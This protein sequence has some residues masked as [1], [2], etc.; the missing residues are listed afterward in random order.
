MPAPR[1]RG[2]YDALSKI[3]QG[4]ARQASA[5]EQINRQLMEREATLHSGDWVGKGATA[6]YREMDGEVMPA[7][8][9]LAA[10]LSSAS[11][12][13]RQI[14]QILQAA[15]QEAARVFR[16]DGVAG[17]VGASAGS[18]AGSS[19][20]GGAAGPS[21]G[22]SLFRDLLGAL[23]AG[24]TAADLLAHLPGGQRIAAIVGATSFKYSLAGID[25]MA[26]FMDAQ[27]RGVST[28]ASGI[29]GAIA[30]GFGYFSGPVGNV[31][32]LVHGVTEAIS[33][34][35]GKYTAIVNDVMPMNVGSALSRGTVDTVDAA[36]RGDWSQL[37]RHHDQ[38]MAGDYGEVVRGYA[39]GFDALGAWVTGD[40]G[41]LGQ[42]SNMAA[43]GSLGPLA[44]FGDWLGGATY[45]LFH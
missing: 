12:V 26:E 10:A 37:A 22:V 5:L 1:V 35:A 15:E 3:A 16:V 32:G 39:I 9:R 8:K 40:S 18:G 29:D 6:F 31:V 43:D 28:A 45:D 38:N 33:P 36:I 19:G 20:A 13:T 44:E 30:G 34:G 4:F 17:G 23:S 41:R 14:V 42:I 7:M 24:G 27:G 11:Q 21:P 2:D 25:G